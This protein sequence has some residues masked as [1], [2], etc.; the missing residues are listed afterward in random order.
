MISLEAITENQCFAV[1]K[2]KNHF[3]VLNWLE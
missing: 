3:A 1:A 2:T